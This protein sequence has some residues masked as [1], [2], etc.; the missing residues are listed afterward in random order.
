MPFTPPSGYPYSDDSSP[1]AN[2]GDI[3][4]A[5]HVNSIMEY[6][7]DVLPTDI[8]DAG[9]VALSD[10][11]PANLGTTAPGVSTEA[12]RA[13]HVHDMPSAADVGAAVQA[14]IDAAISTHSA[15]TDP[16]GDRAYADSLFAQ[17]NEANFQGT[18][19]CSAN[20]NYPAADA[21]D[22]YRVSAAGKIGGASGVDVEIGDLAIC[23]TN[24]T[25]SGTQAAVGA[26][27]TIVQ[28]NLNGAVIGPASSVDDRIALFSGTTGRLIKQASVTVADISG[29]SYTVADTN[30]WPGSDPTTKTTALNTLA[31]RTTDLEA[32]V[33][34]LQ[35][36]VRLV[37]ILVT[38]P[39]G[40][41]LSTGDGKAFVVI[42]SDLNGYVLTSVFAAVSTVSSSG[43]PTVQLARVRAGTPADMLSTRV[44]IDANEYTSETA[45]TPAVINTSNDDVQTSDFIRVDVDVAGTGT[46]GLIVALGLTPP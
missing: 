40:A 12:S 32:E 24:G 29:D 9:D 41:A 22:A 37:Q 11:N 21:D 1:G 17:L 46:K 34:T 31:A 27:W 30:D 44:T 5:E 45:V 18:I 15:A 23:L 4:F 14:D 26:N 16:H 35:A 36:G 10:T 7:E 6:L 13:D 2:D 20:P 38:D 19:D 8:L 25:P 43:T 42:P 28:N 33:D 3:V 39:S